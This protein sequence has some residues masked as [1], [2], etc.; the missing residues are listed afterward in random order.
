[1]KIHAA[2]ILVLALAFATTSFAEVYRF[3]AVN[4]KT[5]YLT[6]GTHLSIAG[7]GRTNQQYAVINADR[8]VSLYSQGTKLEDLTS[9]RS[10]TDLASS[11]RLMNGNRG[12]TGS[13]WAMYDHGVDYVQNFY[14]GGTPT[15]TNGYHNDNVTYKAVAGDVFT[16][17]AF[18]AR[19]DGGIDIV[20]RVNGGLAE[21][22]GLSSETFI[23]LGEY[24]VGG[25]F[26]G[27]TDTNLYRLGWDGTDLTST[28]LAT[29][30]SGTYISVAGH[31][32]Q[33]DRGVLARAD[34][35]LDEFNSGLSSY[36][37]S[38]T[39][40]PFLGTYGGFATTSPPYEHGHFYAAIP[41]PT[42]LALLGLG[43]LALIRRRNR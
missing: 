19:A 22:Q 5:D 39:V 4:T 33:N 15:V 21:T 43:G 17:W 32:G 3:D 28:T 40:F 31:S 35:G 24:A 20:D 16:S 18:L 25:S 7:D 1:M 14:D 6:T 11:A 34:G 38:T 36:F 12:F 41:E 8:S 37:A 10:Y 2:I 13:Y 27:L 23:D 30:T 42:T 29:F 9:A 26:Y